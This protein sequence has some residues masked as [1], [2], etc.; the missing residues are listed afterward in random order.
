MNELVQV[1]AMPAVLSD[2]PDA[3]ALLINGAYRRSFESTI[4]TGRLLI[5]AKAKLA[6]HGT[7]LPMLETKLDFSPDTAQRLMAIARNEFLTNTA[8]VRYLP[9]SSST[10]YALTKLSPEQL[11]RGIEEKIINPDMERKDVDRLR[12]R[13]ERDGH[14]DHTP[15]SSDGRADEAMARDAD[16]ASG[17]GSR[18][19]STTEAPSEAGMG[20][21]RPSPSEAEPEAPAAHMAGRVHPAGDFDFSPTPPWATRALIE[22]VLRHAEREKVCKYQTAWEPA[23]GEGHMAEVLREYFRKVVAIDIDPNHGY[24]DHVG[25]FLDPRNVLVPA[26]DWIITNPPFGDNVLPFIKRALDLAGTGVAMFLQLRYLEGVERYEQI[27]KDRPPTIVAPFVERVPLVMGKYD[28]K[29]STTTAFMWLVWLKGAQPKAPFWIPPGC[30]DALTKP[31][32]AERFT[33]K[34]VRKD[35]ARGDRG[36]CADRVAQGTRRTSR[37]SRCSAEE[38]VKRAIDELRILI[39]ELLLYAALRLMPAKT[40]EQYE[41]ADALDGYAVRIKERLSE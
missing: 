13:P 2:D 1:G 28:P 3:W 19:A 14:H 30:K 25:D 40:V 38:S 17:S 27:Y 26:A 9:R 34:P 39:A 22:R 21:E 33:Q 18:P 16:A 15:E 23:C 20:S 5:E 31:D 6:K 29:A 41:L 4:E 24:A 35:R 10:L 36:N 32:D 8:H 7:W 37:S 11:A 12:P